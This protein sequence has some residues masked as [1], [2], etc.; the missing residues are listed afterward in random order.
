MKH[1]SIEY[2]TLK[3]LI[4]KVTMPMSNITIN[5]YSTCTSGLPAFIKNLN[6]TRLK[7]VRENLQVLYVFLSYAASKCMR[8]RLRQDLGKI[9]KNCHICTTSE[10]SQ[11]SSFHRTLIMQ[12]FKMFW[13]ERW[14][15][16]GFELAFSLRYWD[17]LNFETTVTQWSPS[18]YIN[19]KNLKY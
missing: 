19:K 5:T 12:S 7:K 1:F 13:V 2:P 14:K 9:D 11:L 3:M 17:F 6:R 10:G 18:I 4:Y 8:R 16:V 15:L